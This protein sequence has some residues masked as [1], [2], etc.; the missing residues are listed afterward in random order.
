MEKE[1]PT[2]EELSFC[3]LRHEFSTSGLCPLSYLNCCLPLAPRIPGIAS[4]ENSPT[5]GEPCKYKL[6]FSDGKRYINQHF[7]MFLIKIRVYIRLC[8]L[9]FGNYACGFIGP[10]QLLI[11]VCMEVT[12]KRRWKAPQYQRSS[13]RNVADGDSYMVKT[14]YFLDD[15]SLNSKTRRP[16]D[17]CTWQAKGRPGGPTWAQTN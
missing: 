8:F 6:L 13:V 3:S 15:S 9:S 10:Q 2:M 11:L 12:D 1:P 5:F 7:N 4:K 17:W 14:Q 16:S